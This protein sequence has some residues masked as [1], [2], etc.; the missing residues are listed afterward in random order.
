M[1]SF[2]LSSDACSDIL[3]R[4]QSLGVGVRDAFVVSRGLCDRIEASVSVYLAEVSGNLGAGQASPALRSLALRLTQEDPSDVEVRDLIRALPP[5]AVEQIEAR[6]LRLADEVPAC[7]SL[8]SDLLSWAKVT[9]AT[10]L[11]P[12]LRLCVVEGGAMV[13]GQDRPTDR[14]SAPH[15]EPVVF[16]RGRAVPGLP[17]LQGGRPADN[18]E[19]RLIAHLAVD[20]LE[21]T[22]VEPEAGRDGNSAFSGLVYSVFGWLDIEDKAQHSLRQYW[23]L[24]KVKRLSRW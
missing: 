20:W 4:V 13:P 11:I 15:L 14:Q 6:A 21:S 7:A 9:T 12:L 2:N 5:A 22:S 16:G 8:G 1:T 3:R 23:K 17:K 24:T 10:D 18:A 19:V